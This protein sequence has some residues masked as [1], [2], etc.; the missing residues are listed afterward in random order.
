ML[1]LSIAVLAIVAT[2]ALAQGRSMVADRPEGPIKNP[3][4]I[5]CVSESIIGSRIAQQRVCRTRAE[6]AE[7]RAQAR[8]VVDRVQYFKPSCDPACRPDPRTG[9]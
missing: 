4:Q 7:F 6:W 1:R 9:N 5:V 2:G 3:D 8:G